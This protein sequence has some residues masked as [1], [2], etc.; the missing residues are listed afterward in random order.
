VPASWDQLRPDQGVVA[1]A[2]AE[3]EPA[4]GEDVTHP[5]RVKPVQDRDHEAIAQWV[6]ADRVDV[7][8]SGSTADVLDDRICPQAATGDLQKQTAREATDDIASVLGG[9]RVS[10]PF[11]RPTE[12][13]E[14][15][16]RS[17]S[18]Q[19]ASGTC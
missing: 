13:L 11:G 12:L 14:A 2:R 5:L 15:A 17:S 19:T 9:H 1:S 7:L 6:D 8:A 16:V 3:G 18:P 10:H 4:G